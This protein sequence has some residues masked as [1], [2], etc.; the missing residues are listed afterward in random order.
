[1]KYRVYVQQVNQTVYLVD[2]K[3]KSE[4]A[5]KAQALWLEENKRPNVYIEEIKN[6]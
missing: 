6:V 3:D 1:M 4:A 5:R 2:A